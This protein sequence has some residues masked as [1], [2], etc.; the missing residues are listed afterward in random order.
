MW[1]PL[2]VLLLLSQP[3]LSWSSAHK[4]IRTWATGRLPVWQRD[5]LGPNH[6]T[7]LCKRYTSLQDQ[8]AGGG[9]PDLDAYCA[10]P[11]AEVSLHDS[12]E[13][14]PADT[15]AAMRWYFEQIRRCMAEGQR[16]EAMKYL[17]VLCHW[18][19]DPGSLSAHSSPVSERVMRQLIP[20][21]PHL[22]NRNYLY[23]AGWIDLEGQDLVKAGAVVPSD[24]PYAPKLM[25]ATVIQA[26]CRLH[27]RQRQLSHHNSAYIIP[28][29]QARIRD[30]DA[31][32]LEVVSKAAL[33]NAKLVAD[34][35]YTAGCLAAGRV[36][37]G[38]V[39]ALAVQSLTEW[40][41]ANRGEKTVPPYYVVPYLVNQA[42]DAD[43]N[44]HPLAF[45]GSRGGDPVS[46]GFGVGTPYT[47]RFVFGGAVYG[48]FRARVGLHPTAGPKGKVAFAVLINGKEAYRTPAMSAGA[49]PRLLTVRLPDTPVVRLGIRTIASPGSA[50]GHNLAVIG[51]PRL[52]MP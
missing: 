18:C 24:V 5:Y 30:D 6:L 22:A 10:V 35:I 1:A 50:P 20:P 12:N 43:R 36:S 28:A 26:A 47:L 41:P 37:T 13:D 44:L 15:I 14:R 2:L 29:I 46:H 11:G 32:L 27:Q 31:A 45:A 17:G 25:G 38:D 39:D 23:G 51:E 48:R 40:L 16:D 7:D 34:L 33:Y 3:V 42:I 9:R 49:G 8:H 19:E 21:P 52:E 4:W